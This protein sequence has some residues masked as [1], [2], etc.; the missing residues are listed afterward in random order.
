MPQTSRGV[1]GEDGQAGFMG[2]CPWEASCYLAEGPAGMRRGCAR[3]RHDARPQRS[4]GLH[5]RCKEY[6]GEA[7]S[8][9]QEKRST[10]PRSEEHTSELQSPLN[11][12]CRLLL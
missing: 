9:K 11:L 3:P 4:L 1:R 12:V 10:R 6:A 2:V 8:A 7:P 5:V